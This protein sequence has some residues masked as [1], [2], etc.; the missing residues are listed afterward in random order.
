MVGLGVGFVLTLGMA[1]VLYSLMFLRE[2]SEM[3][4]ARASGTAITP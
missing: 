1:P 4:P 2:E 3:T